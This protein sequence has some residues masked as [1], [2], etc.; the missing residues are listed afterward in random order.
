VFADLDLALRRDGEF[1][2]NEAAS[3]AQLAFLAKVGIDAGGISKGGCARIIEYLHKRR[4][5]SLCT[6][7]QL[8][9]LVR[10]GHSAPQSATFEEAQEFITKELAKSF[11]REGQR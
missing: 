3:N 9:L 2:W 7:R 10:C 1:W 4:Q 6:F 8:R 5:E 11:K